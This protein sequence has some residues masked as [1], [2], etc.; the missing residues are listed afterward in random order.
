MQ[1]VSG[2]FQGQRQVQRI[3]MLQGA[4]L[5]AQAQ[6]V[7]QQADVDAGTQGI[8]DGADRGGG[9]AG[10]GR[11]LLHPG[12]VIV[13]LGAATTAAQSMPSFFSL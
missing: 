13:R 2:A 3:L 1:G 9:V 8:F 5:V 10:H 6:V 11:M 7:F 4:P 12:M